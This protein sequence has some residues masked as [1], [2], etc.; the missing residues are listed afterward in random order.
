L[1]DIGVDCG[2]LGTHSARKGVAT[3]VANGCTIG[4]PIIALC[5]RAGWKLGG[6]KEKYIFRADAGDMAVGRRAAGHNID[7]KEFAISC[8]Y[9]DYSDLDDDAR[10][11][12]QENVTKFL[13]TCLTNR[14]YG[15]LRVFATNMA[16]STR[17]LLQI[18][19]FD[20]PLPFEIFLKTL[21]NVQ[22]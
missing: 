13:A 12:A 11:K 21:G 16:I 1:K 22:Q 8:A 15:V 14:E 4:P 17:T 6:V 3:S 7:T 9:F 19:L 20:S 10:I 2:D 18:H 5:L